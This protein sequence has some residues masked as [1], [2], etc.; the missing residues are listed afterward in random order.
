M[1]TRKLRFNAIPAPC[2]PQIETARRFPG[3]PPQQGDDA[4]VKDCHAV[5]HISLAFA[6]LLSTGLAA[7][8]AH[9]EG[10]RAAGPD[11][12]QP[13]SSHAHPPVVGRGSARD[14]DPR[15]GAA[16]PAEFRLVGAE[17]AA[18]PP[19]ATANPGV[20][21][22]LDRCRCLA[23]QHAVSIRLIDQEL[24][25]VANAARRTWCGDP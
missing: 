24:H 23:A 1:I 21:L 11:V 13:T 7:G 2:D 16:T 25:L 10:T 22:D 4:Q 3:P 8:C 6:A 12:P 15:T 17:I 14:S 5:A 20:P 9:W 18:A 19:P